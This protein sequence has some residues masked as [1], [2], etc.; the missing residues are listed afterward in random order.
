MARSDFSLLALALFLPFSLVAQKDAGR[1]TPEGRPIHVVAFGDF[2]DGSSHQQEVADAIARRHQRSPFD[3]GIT[4]GDNFYRCGV[5]SIHDRKWETRWERFYSPLGITF[6][7][8]LG[9]HDYGHP[10]IICP[11]GGSSAQAE[12]DYTG[13][14]ASWKMP[15]KYYTFTAG[16]VRFIAID[17]EG[18]SLTELE[19]IENTL[20]ES[21]KE[22]D[23][24]WRVVY[25]H[26]PIYTSGVHLNQRKI[27]VLRAQLLPF[28]V[29]G[30]VDF[31]ISGHDHDLEHLQADGI[32]FL[33][34]GGGGAGLR[35]FHHKEA[36]SVFEKSEHAFLDLTIDEH[37]FTARFLDTDLKSAED[38]ILART[39]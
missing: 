29:K 33:I 26:H 22:P 38:P 18:W 19:W 2:G 25:G 32:D 10:P 12:I 3:L 36:E 34:D 28:L 11:Q 37:N 8:T 6:Y 35:A 7:P 9:N 14:S 30:G 5:R 39:K 23:I 17:T 4:M 27:R 13:H 31:Y 1:V 20:D 24:R 16:P 21:A 15:A